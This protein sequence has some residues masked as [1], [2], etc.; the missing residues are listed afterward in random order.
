MLQCFITLAMIDDSVM[1]R[2]ISA[3]TIAAIVVR[4]PIEQ[5]I[6]MIRLSMTC[7]L[8][9]DIGNLQLRVQPSMFSSVAFKETHLNQL[10][11]SSENT[12]G[13]GH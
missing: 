11:L 2:L 12:N 10:L 7:S 4:I 1:D 8:A 6:P 13:C 5:I 3:N 9:S